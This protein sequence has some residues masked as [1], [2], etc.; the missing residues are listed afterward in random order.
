[1]T[2]SEAREIAE[3]SQCTDEAPLKETA[4]Y[5]DWTGAWW[6]DL[7]VEKE[8]CRPA[9][10]V[11]V[12][13]RRVATN[14]RCTGE[15]LPAISPT[16]AHTPGQPAIGTATPTRVPAP[17]TATPTSSPP[18]IPTATTTPTVTPASFGSS[19]EKHQALIVTA[20]GAAEEAVVT[21]YQCA[22]LHV[23][24]TGRQPARP[25]T[26]VIPHGTLLRFEL[27]VERQPSAVD[28]R[29]YPGAGVSASFFRWPEQLPSG[30]KPTDSFQPTP[31][32]TFDYLPPVP[33]G[34]YSVVVRVTW[35]TATDF[36]YAA[37]LRL[38]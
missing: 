15:P 18:A 21:S 8:G 31:S 22:G 2:L 9:C 24:S 20:N 36:F 27:G 35:D 23:D 14:W 30:E 13:T 26:L 38:E 12:R 19:C 3:A 10:V 33:P 28:V 4:I 5:N 7:A 1:M 25:P 17:P 16:A 6:I 11:D 29:L 32:R 34:D 37:S